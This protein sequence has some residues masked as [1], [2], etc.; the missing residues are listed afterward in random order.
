ML[1]VCFSLR[2]TWTFPCQVRPLSLTA[3]IIIYSF[4]TLPYS[5]NNL[6]TWDFCLDNSGSN[7]KAMT[8]NNLSGDAAERFGNREAEK[9]RFLRE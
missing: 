4:I 1:H 5:W 9:F 8:D 3:S 7:A 6:L 2:I